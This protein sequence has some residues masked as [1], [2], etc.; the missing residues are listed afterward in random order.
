MLIAGQYY[1]L[2]AGRVS[3]YG[4]YLTDE[5][6]EVLLPNRYVSEDL[7]ENDTVKVFVYHDSEDRLVAT[8]ET[9]KATAGQVAVLEVVDRTIHGAFL[10]WGLSAKHL[11]LPLSNQQYKVE[12]GQKCVV[13]IYTDNVT[14]RAVATTK[15]TGNIKNIDEL[16]YSYGQ[17]VE[18]IVVQSNNVGFRVIINN[19]HWAMIYHNQIY[20]RISIGDTLTAYVVKVTEDNRIDLSLTKPGFKG[21][22]DAA[23]DLLE[24]I[25]DNGGVLDL[26]DDSSPEDIARIARV[27]KKVFKRSVGQLL[28][29]KLIEFKGNKIVLT[30]K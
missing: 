22:K 15:L 18:A 28:K 20:Q 25:K 2:R 11:F 1:T 23:E 3:D 14:G 7:K 12:K 6:Q 24:I 10:D 26:C 27:S 13:Y 16:D 17:S 9:P 4:V 21:V 29:R 5:E 8:T 30:R 19:K